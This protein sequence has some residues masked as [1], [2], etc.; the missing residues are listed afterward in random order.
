VEAMRHGELP[1]TLH[2]DEPS[3]HVDWSAGAVSLL[4]ENTPW[5]RNGRPRRAAVSSFG[6]SGTNAHVILEEPPAPKP[7]EGELPALPWVVSARS[8]TALRAY[9]GRLRDGVAADGGVDP[10]EVGAAL[11]AARTTF[12]HRAVVLGQDPAGFRDG[13]D[14]LARGQ[15]SPLVVRGS[16]ATPGR[17]AF[18]FAGQGSQRVGMGRELYAAEPVFA[19]AFDAVL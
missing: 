11:V 8:Q 1:R 2:V 7:A 15:E 16:A 13:L 5:P 17:T 3:P 4:T 18:L 10:R 12:E 9:A 6:I 19:E 14:A